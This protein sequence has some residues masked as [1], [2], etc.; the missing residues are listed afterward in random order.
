MTRDVRLILGPLLYNWPAG[1]RLD[2][3][4]AIAADDT[5]DAVV[6]GEVVCAK[7]SPFVSDATL[8]AAQFLAQA[9]KEVV[10]STL[11][12]PV[13]PR[14][15][16][17]LADICGMAGDGVA[18]EANEAGALYLLDGRPHRV[19]PYFNIYNADTLR[20]LARRGATSVCLPWELEMSS[21]EAITGAGRDLGLTVE[22]P[23]FGSIP[24][25]ISARCAHARAH[26]LAKD[27]CQYVCG[28]DAEGMAVGTLDGQT[29][30]RVNGTQTLS[31]AVLVLAEEIPAL[32]AAGVGALRITP[33][34]VDMV[35]VGRVYRDLLNGVADGATAEA[36][37]RALLGDRRAANGYLHGAAGAGW[38][39]MN[40][41][42]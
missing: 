37:L 32:V 16:A 2:F 19:G 24:L 22:V 34:G 18:V 38:E 28:Q 8:E 9:G 23:V 36:K 6:L 41:T 42:A 11:A 10:F 14:E 5:Y 31:D 15:R 27:G 20:V 1:Q 7:R 25:A 26:G 3:Y 30:L 13:T 40:A 35:A 4:R 29:F 39:R 21:V 12:L 33:E 17:E